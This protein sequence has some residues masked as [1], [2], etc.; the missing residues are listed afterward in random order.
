MSAQ[1]LLFKT[2]KAQ[3]SGQM[4][5]ICTGWHLCPAE[6]ACA[7]LVINSGEVCPEHENLPI[8]DTLHRHETLAQT[9]HAV[10]YLPILL[11]LRVWSK[12]EVDHG[13]FRSLRPCENLGG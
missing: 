2:E 12:L 8:V 6:V 10:H 3:I 13:R 11:K 4:Q 1:C 9:A 5:I 7:L